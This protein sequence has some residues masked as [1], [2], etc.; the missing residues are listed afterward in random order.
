MDP[1]DD[2]NECVELVEWQHRDVH[3]VADQCAVGGVGTV[4]KKVGRRYF[5]VKCI[6]NGLH[7]LSCVKTNNGFF[8]M[9]SGK[10]WH[11]Y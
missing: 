1:G 2:Q 10:S 11:R 5:D 4:L 8:S 9:L 6:G 7:A 3:D